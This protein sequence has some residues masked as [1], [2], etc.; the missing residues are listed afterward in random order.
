D[1]IAPQSI[2]VSST[3]GDFVFDRING[4]VA[5]QVIRPTG[6]LDPLIEVRPVGD[7]VD[8]LL[9]EIY[10]IVEKGERELVSTLTILMAEDL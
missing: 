8:D 2:Y 3:P 1:A 5:E 7:Q 6:L 9:S 10:K 4:V